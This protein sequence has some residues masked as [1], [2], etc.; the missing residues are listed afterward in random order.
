LL[1][2]VKIDP[3]YL[4]KNCSLCIVHFEDNQFMNA[5][6]ERLI[7]KAVPTLMPNLSNPPP[8]VTIK[9]PLAGTRNQD[10]P[11]GGSHQ[12]KARKQFTIKNTSQTAGEL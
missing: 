11:D 3:D 10:R 7:W 2:R 8:K 9:R 4:K 6:K 1:E 12:K 5:K